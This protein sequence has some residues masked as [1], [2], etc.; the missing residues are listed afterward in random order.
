[1]YEEELEKKSKPPWEA[2]QK[3]WSSGTFYYSSDFDLTRRLQK[4]F[5]SRR[6]VEFVTT[7][8]EQKNH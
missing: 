1:M 2:L 6:P 4:R 5:V 8:D 7:A 3:V